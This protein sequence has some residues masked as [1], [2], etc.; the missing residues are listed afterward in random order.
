MMKS[1]SIRTQFTRKLSAKLAGGACLA[2]LLLVA[3]VTPAHA[4]IYNPSGTIPYTYTDDDGNLRT[5]AA[6][7]VKTY[8]WTR[9]WFLGSGTNV[10]NEGNSRLFAV[11][12]KQLLD[13]PKICVQAFKS[14]IGWTA[15][16]EQCTTGKNSEITLGDP[17]TQGTTAIQSMIV[18]LKDCTYND[19]LTA[20]SSAANS[21]GGS[22]PVDWQGAITGGTCAQ[23]ITLGVHSSTMEFPIMG[24]FDLK[25][26][27]ND[28]D[29][30]TCSSSSA[31]LPVTTPLAPVTGGSLRSLVAQ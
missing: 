28:G 11:Q 1:K 17:A 9:G 12:F 8:T 15:P 6:F 14:S 16:Q 24:A 22:Y 25:I 29:C 18:R 7:Q 19:N 5:D 4:D 23:K 21:L 31:S 30:A 3:A 10:R 27:R 13:S 26:K 20:D 2:A